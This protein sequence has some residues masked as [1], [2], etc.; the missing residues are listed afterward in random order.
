MQAKNVNN[1]CN[2]CV[3]HMRYSNPISQKLIPLDMDWQ[4]DRG[5]S[6]VEVWKYDP[7]LFMLLD[8]GQSVRLTVL[9]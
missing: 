1:M 3:I 9:A 6:K 2:K 8:G 4:N 7:K 5:R